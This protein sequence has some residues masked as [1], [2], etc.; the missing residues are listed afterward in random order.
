[1]I[2]TIKFLATDVAPR[3]D[4]VDYWVDITDNPYKGTIKY[5]NGTDW[6]RLQDLGGDLDLTKYYSKSEVNNL[7]NEKASVSS[8]ESK[9]DDSEVASLIKNV[10]TDSTVDTLKLI[11]TK[12]DGSTIVLNIPI[13]DNGHT[14]VITSDK[15][16]D[17]VTQSDKQALYIELYTVAEN[18]RQQYQR[19]LIAGKNIKIEDNVISASGDISVE[20]DKILNKPLFKDVATSGDYNDL[21]NKLVPGK[22]VFISDDNVITINL[23]NDYYNTELNKKADKLTT[24]TKEQV[25]QKVTSV[26]KIKGSILFN[27]LPTIDNIVGD[28]YNITDAFELDG[29]PYS[30]GTNVVYTESGWDTLGGTFDTTDLENNIAIVDDKVTQAENKLNVIQGDSSTVGSI[31]KS[32]ADAKTYTNTLLASSYTASDVLTKLK[33]VDGADS[34]LDADTI[35]GVHYQNILERSYSGSSNSGTATGW[36]RIGVAKSISAAGQTFTLELHRSYNYTNNEAYTFSIS[37]AFNGG[38]SITQLSGFAN[39]RL[40]DKIRLDYTSIENIYIDIHISNSTL[41]NTYFWTTIGGATS[42]TSWTSVSDTP[43]ETAYEFTTVDGVKSDRGFTG[44]IVGNSSTATKLQT[45]RYIAGVG[46]DGTASIS[47]PFANL[48]SK[49]TTL[50][51][52]GITDAKIDNGIIT[53]GGN[54]ITPIV[55]SQLDSSIGIVT[56]Q[57][58]THVNNEDIHIP[59][60]A[61]VGQVLKANS[62]GKAEWV[63]DQAEYLKNLIELMS[64]GVEWDITQTTPDCIRVG[65]SLLHKN[66]P[67]QSGLRGCVANG[68]NVNYYLNANNWA[69]KED[70]ITA[71]ILDGTDGT[72]RVDTG[73]TFYGKGFNNGNK[74]QVRISTIQIDSTWIEIPRMLIDSDRCTIDNTNSAT[75]KAVSVVNMT[76]NFRGGGNRVDRDSLSNIATDLGKPRTNLSR[77]LMRTYSQNAGS[78]MLCYEWYKWILYWLPVIEYATFNLQQPFNAALTTDG[79]HQGGLGSG[80][81]TMDSTHWYEFN[82]YYPLTP[83]GYAN[84]LGNFTGVKTFDVDATATKPI[85]TMTIARYRGFS[86]IF[87]DVWTNVD[88]IIIQNDTSSNDG[89]GNYTLKNVYATS[90]A[91][92]FSDTITTDYKLIGKEINTDGYTKEFAIGNRAEIIPITIGGDTTKNKCDYH[93]TG[94][95][96]DTSLRTLLFGGDAAYGALAGLGCFRSDGAVGYAD[97]H[98]GFRSVNK[99]IS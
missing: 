73:C 52:Y 82:G 89:S 65:N 74:R 43:T 88:G 17:L 51:N 47:I 13:A 53:L 2:T 50:A 10:Q 33:T 71:S 95:R 15:Y 16:K 48:S 94:S 99:F 72:V 60:G 70:G 79:Y 1:M 69:Y 7:L 12:Y 22:D 27:Q 23:D 31:N 30:P 62:A 29:K 58:N 21:I 59:S 35:D 44:D 61:T 98:I 4:E 76:A 25:D 8:V 84:D 93:Y 57:L 20:W 3:P 81:T 63:D 46:F 26:Y 32:L 92:K 90:D 5:F 24:Y 41:D 28:T 85:Q 40:I 86:N 45:V 96:T 80:V 49:P 18:I 54:T 97:S 91:S 39:I 75:P 19:K 56:T 78:E 83:C 55:Q 42:Y 14:G 36:F 37:A 77:A 34:G 11:S 38:I 6:I 67:I 66:L 68:G 9:L 64:Y 87:G